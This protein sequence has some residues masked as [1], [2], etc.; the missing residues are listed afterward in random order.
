MGTI[1]KQLRASMFEMSRRAAL[2]ALNRPMK[3]GK[4]IM[5]KGIPGSGKSTWAKEYVL[6]N[7]NTVRVNNDELAEM[8]FN[9]DFPEKARYKFVEQVRE[10]IILEALEQ[11]FDV[12]IDNTNLPAKWRTR[13]SDLAVAHGYKF[14]VIDFT[15]MPLQVCIE[16][17]KKRE[18]TIPEKVIV[19]M[20][21][22]FVKQ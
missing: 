22:K 21:N 3:M 13:Y 4:I 9:N 7:P 6:A 17:N 11:G 18:R 14:E 1:S 19:D 8:M 10:E 2:S 15:S 5:M 20:Y 16:R 12:L